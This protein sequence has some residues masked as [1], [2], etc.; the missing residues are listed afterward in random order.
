MVMGDDDSH[1]VGGGI[2]ECLA[3]EIELVLIE[4]AV[5][6]CA[7]RSAGIESDDH[8]VIE[9]PDFVQSIVDILA[10]KSVGITEAFEDTK[11]RH[12]VISGNDYL[13][14]I[15]QLIEE[16]PRLF[17]LLG[18]GTLGEVSADDDHV[19]LQTFGSPQGR[20]AKVRREWTTEVQIGEMQQRQHG[21]IS[22]CGDAL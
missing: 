22:G 13:G 10:I 20:F 12:V 15:G 9:S 8:G 4:A 21:T 3:A 14:N 1:G 16:L 7:S 17:E 6:D 19:G 5:G 2:G 18:L 11:K